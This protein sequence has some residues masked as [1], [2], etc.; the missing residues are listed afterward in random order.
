MDTRIVK[1]YEKHTWFI[2]FIFGFLM[3]I[4]SPINLRGAPPNPPSPESMT[5][6]TL[7]EISARVPG[8]TGYISGISRQLGNFMLLAGALMM[9]IA[10]NPYRRGEKWAWYVSWILPVSLIIQIINSLATGGFLWEVD[11]A[12]LLV[13]LAGLLLP[14][15]KFFPKNQIVPVK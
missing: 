12:S 15:R 4:A 8:I 11:L 1:G 13:I 5:G 7:D 10:A 2:L 3:V 6:L 9:G 14:Y